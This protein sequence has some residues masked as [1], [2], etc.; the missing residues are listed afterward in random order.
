AR[1]EQDGPR[2]DPLRMVERAEAL[3]GEVDVR[4]LEL[5]SESLVEGTAPVPVAWRIA[6]IRNEEGRAALALTLQGSLPF[7][8]QRCLETFAWPLQQETRVLV[9]RDDAELKALDDVTDD[10][11]ILGSEQ[12]GAHVLVEDELLLS[13]PFAPV[14]PGACP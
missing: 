4:S 14:H 11:V 1:H 10:E 2:V 5:A 3:S 9:A 7:T 6:G 12:V 8:C 13:M